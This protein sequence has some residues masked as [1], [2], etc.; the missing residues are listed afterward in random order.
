MSRSA[1]IEIL[2]K[3]LQYTPDAPIR[4][5]FIPLAGIYWEDELPA[6]QTLIGLP[7]IE[8][9]YPFLILN[10]RR[11]LWA[12][13]ALTAEEQNHWQEAQERFPNWPIFKRLQ[14]SAADYQ[15]QLACEREAAQ[16]RS[17]IAPPEK[18]VDQGA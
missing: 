15:H 5:C 4:A 18:S 11:K 13:E 10:L 16:F 12:H 17:D 6:Y 2:L 9:I 3:Q 8:Y 7:E 1:N 14:I